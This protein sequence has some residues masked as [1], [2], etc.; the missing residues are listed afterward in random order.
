MYLFRKQIDSSITPYLLK[1]LF[2]GKIESYY[3]GYHINYPLKIYI[4]DMRR[5]DMKSATHLLSTNWNIMY[6]YMYLNSLGLSHSN[7]NEEEY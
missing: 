7:F 2:Y 6:N 5:Y 3:C 1:N 4:V